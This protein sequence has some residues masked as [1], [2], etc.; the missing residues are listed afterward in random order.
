MHFLQIWADLS[1]KLNILKQFILSIRKTLSCPSGKQ[2]LF[3]EFLLKSTRNCKKDTIFDNIRTTNQ[4]GDTKTT[5]MT[6]SF[7]TTVRTLTVQEPH[8]CIF[9]GSPF[10]PFWFAK[11]LNFGGES[12]EIRIQSQSIQET[13]TLWNM[14]NQVLL[15]LSS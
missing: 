12:C 14:K 4:E 8:F 10:G 3:I 5:L 7:L 1:K 15:F 13:Y 9:V 11:Y 2:Y 6:P